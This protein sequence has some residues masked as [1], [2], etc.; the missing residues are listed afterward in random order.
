MITTLV[1][2]EGPLMPADVN[3]LTSEHGNEQNLF[4]VVVPP[5]GFHERLLQTLENLDP[6]QRP[7]ADIRGQHPE[8]YAPD[9][10]MRSLLDMD[11]QMI[12]K[13]IEKP[14]HVLRALAQQTKA[15]ELVTLGT[16]HLLERLSLHG[17]ISHACRL[18]GVPELRLYARVH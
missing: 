8:V 2:V 17:W 13:N 1:L 5:S 4:I 3:M 18:I 7:P 11:A 14:L 10:S 6:D 16:P 9:L 12:E 15:D